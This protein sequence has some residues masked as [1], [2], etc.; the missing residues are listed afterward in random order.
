MDGQQDYD[1][2][3]TANNCTEARD[4]L[5]CLRRVPFEAFLSTVD[6]TPDLFS[7]KSLA[8]VWRP[9]VDGDIIVRNPVISVAHGAFAPV[10]FQLLTV[11][12][13]W[14]EQ[15]LGCPDSHL[16]GRC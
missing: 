14:I 8:L 5:E 9:R 16:G 15:I 7:F 11:S 3:V 6:Q 1:D 4:T 10:C 13:S 12:V 2:L